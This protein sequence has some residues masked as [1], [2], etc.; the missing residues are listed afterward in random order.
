MFNEATFREILLP[1]LARLNILVH[2]VINFIMPRI[3]STEQTSEKF[4]A[5]IPFYTCL[6][7]WNVF[8]IKSK[9]AR[10]ECDICLKFSVR[11]LCDGT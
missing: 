2:G 7:A 8:I 10:V 1:S 6:V 11:T 4:F 3:M 9:G 5:H